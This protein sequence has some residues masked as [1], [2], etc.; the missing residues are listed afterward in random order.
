MCQIQIE[1]EKRKVNLTQ[2][3]I[4]DL[5]YFFKLIYFN[6]DALA[7]ELQFWWLKGQKNIRF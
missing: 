2:H 7:S 1:L 4:Y 5:K 6:F 3:I